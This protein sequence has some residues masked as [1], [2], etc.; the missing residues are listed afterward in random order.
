MTR[1]LRKTQKSQRLLPS[2]PPAL[3]NRNVLFLWMG[4]AFMLATVILILIWA[5]FWR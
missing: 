2:A 5:L 4:V 1:R 3:D